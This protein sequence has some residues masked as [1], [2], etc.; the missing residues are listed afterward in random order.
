MIGLYS[1]QKCSSSFSEKLLEKSNDD[2][3]LEI[4]SKIYRNVESKKLFAEVEKNLK[5]P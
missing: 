4:N 3:K 2:E 1:P 5:I